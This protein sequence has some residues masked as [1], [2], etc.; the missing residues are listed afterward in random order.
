V[1]RALGTLDPDFRALIERA[2]AP[3]PR[4]RF[5][6]ARAL[7]DALLALGKNSVPAATPKQA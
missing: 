3:L 2:M 1:Q 7:R 4:Q 5:A 6:D